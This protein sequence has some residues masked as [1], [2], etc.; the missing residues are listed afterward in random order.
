MMFHSA[1]LTSLSCTQ[2]Q[3]MCATMGL[4]IPPKSQFYAL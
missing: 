2:L 1:L 3:E 4:A